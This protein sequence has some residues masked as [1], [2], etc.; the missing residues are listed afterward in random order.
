LD[1]PDFPTIESVPGRSSKTTGLREPVCS[2]WRDPAVT[3]VRASGRPGWGIKAGR[4][5]TGTL[6]KTSASDPEFG[7]LYTLH[8]WPQIVI[9]T[10][11][12]PVY[13]DVEWD[14]ADRAA[15]EVAHMR[16]VRVPDPLGHRPT[17]TT[18]A[19][20]AAASARPA[21]PTE[22]EPVIPE[23]TMERLVVSSG[24]NQLVQ[25][26]EDGWDVVIGTD[27]ERFDDLWNAVLALESTIG[28]DPV[29]YH[30]DIKELLDEAEM[31]DSTS[32]F[33]HS[34]D[35][36]YRIAGL[37][38][39]ARA[40]FFPEEVLTHIGT[41]GKWGYFVHL[42]RWEKTYLYSW[43][44]GWETRSVGWESLGTVTRKAAV[45]LARAEARSLRLGI[46]EDPLGD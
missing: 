41:Y 35:G 3:M 14:L 10:A 11:G 4:T 25:V 23:R 20:S 46:D 40:A 37:W 45:E 2:P 31:A 17:K 13:I 43:D 36:R 16:L 5:I 1:E 42:Y 21:T 22:P 33:V 6:V 44:E 24:R 27:T 32:L 28:S 7:P 39:P 18:G 8:G 19:A 26:A 9:T 38:L 15:G 30:V 34:P 12:E 29:T